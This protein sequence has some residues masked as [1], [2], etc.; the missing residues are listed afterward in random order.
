MKGIFKY[1]A[2]VGSFVLVVV[3][4]VVTANRLEESERQD[5]IN[6]EI[7]Q[8]NE[9]VEYYNEY[10]RIIE[11]TANASETALYSYEVLMFI[12][13]NPDYNISGLDEKAE[14]MLNRALKYAIDSEDMTY[15]E[16]ESLRTAVDSEY[17]TD[18]NKEKFSEIEDL[19]DRYFEAK[20]E[21][22]AKKLYVSMTD[23][24]VIDRKGQPNDKSKTTTVDGTREIWYYDDMTVYIENNHVYK[25]TEY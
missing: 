8:Q 5:K 1:G 9:Y 3:I 17:V 22:E 15:G 11:E 23:Y 19:F 6:Q 18:S 2:I 25:F 16:A 20:S 10:S 7:A 13:D 21:E 14:N 4:M 24:E 12:K